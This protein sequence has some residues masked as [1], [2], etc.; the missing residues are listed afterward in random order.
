MESETQRMIQKESNS[1]LNLNNNSKYSSIRKF[2]V[3]LIIIIALFLII[4]III[5]YAAKT[6]QLKKVKKQNEINI[7]NRINITMAELNTKNNTSKE[8]EEITYVEFNED[9]IN[10]YKEQLNEFCIN[11]N[12]YNNS[13]YEKKIK[14]ANVDYLGKK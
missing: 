12:I 4:I 1:N 11:E 13:E 8:L 14:K 3:I 9:I 5:I 2:V 10:K 7:I 6:I